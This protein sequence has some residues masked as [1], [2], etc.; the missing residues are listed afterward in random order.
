MQSFFSKLGSNTAAV[1]TQATEAVK[2]KITGEPQMTEEEKEK[3][4]RREATIKRYEEAKKSRPA[5]V[6]KLMNPVRAPNAMLR[7][8][9]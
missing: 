1:F 4:Q 9:L 2:S 5:A 6:P 7:V 8:L 3:Q